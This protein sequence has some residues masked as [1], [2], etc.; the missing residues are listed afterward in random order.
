MTFPEEWA[1]RM[2]GPSDPL[3]IHDRI[4]VA[5]H[6]RFTMLRLSNVKFTRTAA[7]FSVDEMDFRIEFI[8][9]RLGHRWQ[10]NLFIP[11]IQPYPMQHYVKRSTER[12]VNGAILDFMDAVEHA[13]ARRQRPVNLLGPR[14]VVD[15]TLA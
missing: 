8:K 15:N 4:M 13:V 11:R 3:F 7:E 14:L 9:E 1:D 2:V 12:Q 6:S 10:L 5:L